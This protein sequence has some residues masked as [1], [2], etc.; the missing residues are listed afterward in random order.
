[1]KTF[2]TLKYEA[3]IAYDA[4]DPSGVG[5]RRFEIIEYAAKL[6]FKQL[7]L[8]DANL[9]LDEFLQVIKSSKRDPSEFVFTVSD[10]AYTISDRDKDCDSQW[11]RFE[12]AFDP[13]VLNEV[14]KELIK[15]GVHQKQSERGNM[16]CLYSIKQ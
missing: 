5:M 9:I 6:V 16:I 1:M 14:V 7:G 15:I 8:R 2:E 12:M 3:A 13:F 4:A 10:E 11:I